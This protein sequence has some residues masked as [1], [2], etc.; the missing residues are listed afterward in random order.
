MDICF[1]T[2]FYEKLKIKKDVQGSIKQIQKN[3]NQTQLKLKFLVTVQ[4]MNS[5]SSI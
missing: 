3:H 2:A 4:L 1:I 5:I